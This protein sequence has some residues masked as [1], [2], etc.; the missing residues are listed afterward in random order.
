[1]TTWTCGAIDHGVTFYSNGTIAPCCVID[2]TYRKPIKE[3][4]N[5]PFADLKG[6][7]APAVC[8]RCTTAEHQGISSARQNFNQ[9]RS[10]KPGLQ[11]VDIRNSNFCNYKCRS[12]CADNSSQWADEL[13]YAIPILKHDITDYMHLITTDSLQSVYYTGGEPFING[14]QWD[15]L[16]QL[17]DQGISH[18]IK[19]SYNTNLSTLHYKDRDI[20]ELWQQFKSVSVM[21]SIDAVGE[22][23]NYI[24]SGGDWDRVEKNIK[25]LEVYQSKYNNL[26][27]NIACTVSILNIWSI[28]ELLQYFRNYQITLTDLHYP[29]YLALTTIPDELQDLALRCVD[30]IEVLYPNK[31]KCDFFRQQIRNNNTKHLFRDTVMQTL[32]LDR[33]RNEKLFDFL[34]FKPVA[35]QLL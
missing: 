35:L 13:N 24:R 22:K 6:G 15:L 14:E 20:L 4:S 32:L 19:L 23:F 3:L 26:A 18:N 25:L 29:D 9:Q 8:H 30:D 11:F 10:L 12:C 7:I 33:V 27:M 17:I 31:N 16:Q 34:P 28:P 1:M 21:V 5:N 2:H